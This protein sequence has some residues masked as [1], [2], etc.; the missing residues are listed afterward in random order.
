MRKG[1]DFT[2]LNCKWFRPQHGMLKWEGSLFLFPN[3][4]MLQTSSLNNKII[5]GKINIIVIGIVLH[6]VYIDDKPYKLRAY[7]T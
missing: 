6:L 7:N 4:A 1:E 2:K 3:L 5:W